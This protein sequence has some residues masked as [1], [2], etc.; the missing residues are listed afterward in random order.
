MGIFS[1][2]AKIVF[3]A[4]WGLA[5][6]CLYFAIVRPQKIW[7]KGLA[8]ATVC[9]IFGYLPVS[10]ELEL[11]ANRKA[12]VALQERACKAD[13][14]KQ[15]VTPAVKGYFVD[16]K[17]F[18]LFEHEA[19]KET[20]IRLIL[21][22]KLAFL[23]TNYGG[24]LASAA[25]S[26]SATPPL[27]TYLRFSVEPQGATECTWFENWAA[28]YP[29]QKW[30]W[31]RSLG[32]QPGY[33]IAARIVENLESQ[34][35]VN[36]QIQ[37]I[38]VNERGR[39]AFEYEIKLDDRIERKNVA[40]LRIVQ[41]IDNWEN[42]RILC[43]KKENIKKLDALIS[44]SPHPQLLELQPIV[45][46]T[47]PTL[48]TTGET[49][50]ADN[51][52]FSVM[53]PAWT[54]YST[55]SISNDG[56][57]WFETKYRRN[58]H[59]FSLDGYYL[60]TIWNNQMKKTLIRLNDQNITDF[61]ALAVDENKIAFLAMNSSNREQKTLLEYRKDGTPLRALKYAN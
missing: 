20:I 14:I 21:E 9:T 10:Q 11:R 4:Y 8:I 27:P 51:D 15:G 16:A 29:A 39:G 49:T 24:E 34:I 53:R 37:P 52:R 48:V 26:R 50:K 12:G 46:D 57:V 35:L 42:R 43:D 19:K 44:V 33:C 17:F 13:W 25:R 5:L 38:N 47:P 56:Q 36:V 55:N 40:E 60:V 6:L 32:L 3:W 45:V 1:T 23:E 7:G 41:H 31:M 61:H 30:P 2:I 59:G 28:E 58:D 54:T 22:R 18:T